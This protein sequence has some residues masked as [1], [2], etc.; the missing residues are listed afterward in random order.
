MAVLLLLAASCSGGNESSPGDEGSAGADG[1][2]TAGTGDEAGASTGPTSNGEPKTSCQADAGLEEACIGLCNAFHES[3]CTLM[4][5]MVRDIYRLYVNDDDDDCVEEC[6][7]GDIAQ[8]S[9]PNAPTKCGSALKAYVERAAQNTCIN[10]D[11]SKNFYGQWDW[12]GLEEEANALSACGEQ[13]LDL[14]TCSPSTCNGSMSAGDVFC[15][16][17]CKGRVCEQSCN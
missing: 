3:G 11:P 5:L 10:I 7:A 14:P 8:D 16:W 12:E 4:D 15:S 6:V 9:L 2:G 1:S 13:C 17:A